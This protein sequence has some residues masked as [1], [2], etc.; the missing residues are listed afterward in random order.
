MTTTL[1]EIAT[2]AELFVHDFL[3]A[4]TNE[5][6]SLYMSN[7]HLLVIRNDGDG[8]TVEPVS[9][10]ADVYELIDEAI[11]ETPFSVRSSDILAVVTSGWAA[12]LNANG[13]VD[14]RPSEH[15]QRRRVRLMACVR[16]SDL[17]VT[18]VLRFGDSDEVVID[19]GNA[20]GSLAEALLSLG[21]AG[22]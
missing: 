1:T 2:E 10:H 9:S 3:G 12:P 5:Q 21:E 16:R 4:F 11:A 19:E 13:D 6:D 18:S 8:V 14:G 20:T 22:K 15:A 17:S 7:A